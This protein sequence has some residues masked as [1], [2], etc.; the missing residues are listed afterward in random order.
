MTQINED[1]SI[2]LLRLRFSLYKYVMYARLMV[3]T[4]QSEPATATARVLWSTW[5]YAERD[6]RVRTAAANNHA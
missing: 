6:A 3:Q 4:S 2:E 5:N 1:A